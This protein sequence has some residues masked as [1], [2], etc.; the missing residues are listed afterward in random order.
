MVYPFVGV[1]RQNSLVS[2]SLLTQ[3]YPTCFFT[4]WSFFLSHLNGFVIWKASG[5]TTAVLRSAASRICSKQ[6]VVSCS[7]HLSFSL[8]TLLKSLWCRH[9]IVLTPLQLGRTVFFLSERSDFHIVDSSPCLSY[10]YVNI[11]FS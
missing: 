9:A 3:K 6:L 2:L 10:A 4:F 7:F 1:H 11:T 8:S 5:H